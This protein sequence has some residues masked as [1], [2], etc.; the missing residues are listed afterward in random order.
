MMRLWLLI[1]VILFAPSS[2]SQEDNIF[3]NQCAK[4]FD[5]GSV[6]NLSYPFWTG[7]RSPACGLEGFNLSCSRDGGRFPLITIQNH[8]FLVL[9]VNPSRNEMAISRVDVLGDLCPG[10]ATT[11]TNITLNATRFGFV[12]D[13]YTKFANI[14]LFYNCT[15]L[16]RTTSSQMFPCGVYG[17]E[18]RDAFY[19]YEGLQGEWMDDISKCTIIVEIPV[20]KTALQDNQLGRDD[21][22]RVLEQGFNVSYMYNEN[23][24]SCRESGGICGTNLTTSGFTCFC[25][26]HSNPVSCLQKPGIISLTLCISCFKP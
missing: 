21:L 8:D 25:S 7:G 5:C 22:S 13:F 4:P 23:C 9:S 19:G 18:E 17:G 12:P 3:Y 16:Q 2:Y 26:D 11:F 15:D 6:S 20:P 24:G 10:E 1:L 14:S